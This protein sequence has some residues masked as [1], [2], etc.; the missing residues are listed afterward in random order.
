MQ[1]TVEYASSRAEVWRTYWRS[2]TRPAGLWRFHVATALAIALMS[3]LLNREAHFSLERFAATAAIV[4]LVCVV[5]FP[6]WLQLR[7]KSV[8]RSL[9]I[10]P[11]GFKTTIG[12][13]SG[14][15]LW[16]E[17]T[18]IED[19][20]EEILIF[21]KSGNAMVVPRRA[22]RDDAARTKFLNDAKTWNSINAA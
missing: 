2:W 5:L 22:F 15:R 19:T 1:H 13:L 7:F 20:G 11:L 18:S 14:T 6:L 12:S 10:D 17:V 8:T 16:K 9:T 3:S 4:V 21:G